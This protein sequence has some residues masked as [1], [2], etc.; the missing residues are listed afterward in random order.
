[1]TNILRKECFVPLMKPVLVCRVPDRA[2]KGVPYFT[3]AELAWMKSAGLE[4]EQLEFLYSARLLDP[5]YQV[6]PDRLAIKAPEPAAV[7]TPARQE[8]FE[9][10]AK[11]KRAGQ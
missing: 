1:M 8:F 5:D 6:L 9:F 4:Q 3:E 2:A 7:P 11:S 10:V